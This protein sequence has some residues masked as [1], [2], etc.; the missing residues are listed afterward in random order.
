[1]VIYELKP[2][3]KDEILTGLKQALNDS[4]RG[5]GKY[6]TAK[7]IDDSK[8]TYLAD[9]T[10]G[11]LRLALSSLEILV[12]SGVPFDEEHIDATLGAGASKI[13]NGKDGHYD[14]IAWYCEAIKSSDV[15]AA[16]L[17]LGVLL[18]GN[19]MESAIRRIEVGLFEDIGVANIDLWA[20]VIDALQVAR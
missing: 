19:D 7:K 17:A 3:T 18:N 8:L 1:M 20:P 14:T 4:D 5:L 10:N 15:N 16:L 13:D 12:K 6:E 11:D 9:R 2:L